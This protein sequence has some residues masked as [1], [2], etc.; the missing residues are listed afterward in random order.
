MK[1]DKGHGGD[2]KGSLK[3]KA[4]AFE[5]AFRSA[6]SVPTKKKKSKVTASSFEK[7]FRSSQKLQIAR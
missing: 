7:A 1:D 2:S 4:D 6:Q 5:S 3:A